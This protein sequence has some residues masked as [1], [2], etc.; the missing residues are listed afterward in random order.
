M[1]TIA[2][3]L[4]YLVD[5]KNL[6]KT[7]IVGKG[8]AF[9]GSE[10]LSDYAT[11]INNISNECTAT[12]ANILSGKTAYSGGSKITGTIASKGAQTYSPS[13]SAQTIT[14]G[15]YLSGTQ[16]ISAVTGTA[17]ASDV[18][19]TKTFASASGVGITGTMTNRGAVTSTITTQGG[20]Y[21]VPVGYH[22]GSGKITASFANLSAG[23]IKSGV[24]VGGLVGTLPD[25]F[26][27][28]SLSIGTLSVAGTIQSAKS[29]VREGSNQSSY[30]AK[31]NTMYYIFNSSFNFGVIA[32]ITSIVD[33]ANKTWTNVYGYKSGGNSSDGYWV[34]NLVYGDL[35]V[36]TGSSP[37]Y[38]LG[39]NLSVLRD[40]S[41]SVGYGVAEI[42]A[43][44][45][46]TINIAY[47]YPT[48]KYVSGENTT[49]PTTGIVPSF[50]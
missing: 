30:Y 40:V 39:L 36:K 45:A 35:N 17:V 31:A 21:T 9:S 37:T 2:D 24:N 43:T 4:Q 20:Q 10:T 6:I 33:S 8:Q 14:A 27:N 12:T 26:N 11:K 42:P 18:L 23:N 44:G 25:K 38:G 1:G 49:V 7:A 46:C 22:S 16:T 47:V 19:A 3:K 28:L 15:Q 50:T 32:Y 41:W 48:W 5:A 34:S 29:V 13:T